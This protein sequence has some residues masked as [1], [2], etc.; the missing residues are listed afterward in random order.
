MNIC[1][2]KCTC[3]RTGI[4]SDYIPYSVSILF[5]EIGSHSCTSGR[6]YGQLTLGINMSLPPQYRDS[7]STSN[8]PSLVFHGFKAF[9]SGAMI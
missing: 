3:V 8:I 6:V 1:A 4:A 2:C 7:K 9:K 5:I